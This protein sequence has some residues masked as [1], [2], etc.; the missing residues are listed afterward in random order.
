MKIAHIFNGIDSKNENN[1]DIFSQEF[2][3]SYIEKLLDK[4]SKNIDKKDI[5]EKFYKGKK[6]D[7][8]GKRY[9][10]SL[11]SSKNDNIISKYDEEKIDTLVTK[12]DNI[13]MISGDFWGIQKFI[14]DGL[15]AKKAS[16]ILR[17][18]SAMVQLITFAV[19]DIIKK[20]FDKSDVV[21]FGAGKFL[22]LASCEKD[23]EKQIKKIQTELDEYFLQ[24]FF[25]LNG[26][27]LSVVQTHSQ[28]ILKQKS[29][30]LEEDLK[31]LAK[32]NELNKLQ[33]FN[34]TDLKDDDIRI[35]IFANND[36][37][38]CKFCGKR[39]VAKKNK[40]EACLICDN[41]IKLG[42]KLTKNNYVEISTQ[43]KDDDILILELGDI[44]YY[45]KFYDNEPTTYRKNIFDISAGNYE[46]F[47]KWSLNSY[48]AMENDKIKDFDELCINEY[49]NESSGLMAMK[50]DVDKLGDTFR[51]FYQKDFK[52][53]NR[54]SREMDFFFSDYA[55]SLMEKKNLY[56]V[57]AGGDD[58]FVIGEYGEIIKYAKDLRDK[59]YKFSL[60]KSTLSMGLVMFKPSTPINY[61]S[62]LADEA[63]IRAKNVTYENCDKTRDGIDLFGIP[64]KFAEF[65]EIEDDFKEI[66]G[67]LVDNKIE[68]TTFY[69]RLIEFCDMRENL[70][71]DEIDYRNA[72]WKSKLN[73]LFRRNVKREDNDSEIFAK[74]NCLI[75]TYG[76][77][78]KPS[79]F[80]KIYENRDNK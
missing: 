59:F 63:E 12:W 5:L 39:G 42:E 65:I 16:K 61:I 37:E 30:K 2:E 25:G 35:N 41:Q 51:N 57:F 44:K 55:T 34:F 13:L 23:Y 52:K 47:P 45:A 79:I 54:L 24:K 1:I 76:E 32:E 33:K 74:L 4:D 46:I 64:M 40:N 10:G 36:N 58:L 20:R 3:T 26:F 67:F 43:K 70:K 38:V 71:S 72:M 9:Y 8:F 49:G 62:R 15:T 31:K 50:A 48:V 18:R 69:Y 19:V 53:F 73:Y 6:D 68:T 22:I 77:K 78:F 56:T 7:D 28:N 66:V 75:E 11:L 80:L 21:L 29:K 14:F 27:I 17:S 60:K